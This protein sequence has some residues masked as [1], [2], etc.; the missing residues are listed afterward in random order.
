MRQGFGE[1]GWVFRFNDRL[2]KILKENKVG[3]EG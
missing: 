2:Y 1:N 3:A